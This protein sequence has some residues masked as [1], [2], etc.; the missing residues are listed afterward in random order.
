MHERNI[1]LYIVSLTGLFF[2][3]FLAGFLAPILGKMELL[4]SPLLYT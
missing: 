2:G 3:A 1:P 4:V